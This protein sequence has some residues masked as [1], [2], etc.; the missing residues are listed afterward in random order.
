[1]IE[2]M[3]DLLKETAEKFPDKESF[4]GRKGSLF[5]GRTFGEIKLITDKIIAGLDFM[6]VSIGEKIIY[7]CDSSPNW[8]LADLA[9]ISSGAVSVPRGTDV[10]SDDIIYIINHSESK[11]AIVQKEKDRQKLISL[12]AK[13]PNLKK[14]FVLET[15]TGELATGKDTIG[16]IIDNGKAILE[17]D[18]DVVNNRLSKT[19]PQ[20][21]A[22]LIYTSGTTGAP[23]GVMLNQKGWITAITHTIDRVNLNSSD[24]GISLLPPWHAFERAIE[25]AS[26]KLGLDFLITDTKT[27][28]EDLGLF[29]PTLFPSVPRIWESLY[30]GIMA[31]VKKESS[32]KQ[33]IFNFALSV[34]QVW[35]YQKS[36]LLGYRYSINKP[37]FISNVFTKIKSA[38]VLVLLFP[39][40]VF[41]NIVFNPIHRALGGRLRISVSA[42][43]ALPTVVD[44][45]L[46]ALGLKVLEGYG[47]T[48]TSAVVSIRD[49]THPTPGTLGTPLHGYQI[50]LTNEMGHDITKDLG[51]KGTL[52]IKSEQILTGYYKRQD[53][54]EDCFDEDGFFNTGDLMTLNYKGELSF[55]GRSKDTIVLAGGENIEP[56]PIE[57]KLL[58]SEYIDQIIVIGQ[59]KKTPSAIIVP[60]FDRVKMTLTDIPD[61]YKLWN[62]NEKIRILFKKE[63]TNLISSKNGFKS[64]EYIPGNNFYISE[65]IFDPD[66]EM[67]RT[68][69]MKRNVICDHFQKQIES[70]YN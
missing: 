31:K 54:N 52:W 39:A 33:S 60:N 7:F 68:L 5:K 12:S 57:D 20:E 58:E 13:I 1:M 40:K 8:I 67:T 25:Y 45:F 56:L 28:K 61:E 34:G 48:E 32:L 44:N 6:N 17:K 55:T 53:L 4:K 14:I 59:D 38:I 22:T 46:T 43:S 15:D 70:I 16:E 62:T 42:G 36:G 37:V 24:S 3:Y 21:L 9:I 66:T 19:N 30:N 26:L 69:K 35:A 65:K 47:M 10:T 29:K 18:P 64:F 51:R 50:K 41:A 63:I 27:L 49:M 11:M 23:K 2:R